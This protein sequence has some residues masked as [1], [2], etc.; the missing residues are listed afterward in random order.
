M[1]RTVGSN[2]PK[3]EIRDPPTVSLPDRSPGRTHNTTID[4][5][6]P[7]RATDRSSRDHVDTTMGKATTNRN[8]ARNAN[9]KTN[10]AFA[11]ETKESLSRGRPVTLRAPEGQ[12]DLKTRWH[13][14]AK[15]VAY[16]LLDL[17]KEGSKDY[18]MFDKGRVHKELDAKYQFDPP[19]DPKRVDKYLAGHLRTSRGVWK[20]HWLKYGDSQRHHNCPEEAWEKLI[21][22]WPTDACM[23]EASTMAN[24][25]SLVQNSSK[26]C[27]NSLVQTMDEEVR[28]KICVIVVNLPHM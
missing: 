16:N 15:K 1:K 14:A 7:C 25:R 27:Q 24:R 23:E 5:S 26:T 19:L 20:A 8:Q 9:R 4:V 13:T 17:R 18:S 21:N 11:R 6:P 10:A 2:S 22:W 12:N 28:L 3:P